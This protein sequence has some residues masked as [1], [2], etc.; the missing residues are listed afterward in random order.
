MRAQVFSLLFAAQ[1]LGQ[2]QPNASSSEIFGFDKVVEALVSA[3]DHADVVAL[4][5]DHWRKLDSD[6][7][8]QLIR[9]PRFA[10]KVR[11]IVVEFASTAQQPTLDRYIRGED[12]PLADLQKV[13]RTTTQT[14]GVWESSVY[15]DFF[16]AVRELNKSLPADSR[17]RV[18]AGDP[19]AGSG[20][21]RDDSAASIVKK[22]VLDK[23]G[24]ALVIYGA[25]HLWRTSPTGEIGLAGMLEANSPGRTFVVI[26]KG[27]TSKEYEIFERALK[28]SLRPVLVQLGKPP[29]R[30]FAADDLFGG[31][32]KK[33]VNGEWVSAFQ[34]SGITL[35]QMAD[36][37]IYLGMAPGVDTRIVPVRERPV[38]I[39]PHQSRRDE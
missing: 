26:T 5:D 36:A 15:A 16:G 12:V 2:Q 23:G 38:S 3:F 4:G 6:I 27:G 20:L 30:D 28:T 32:L 39:L 21:S 29:F 1:L 34:G 25:A 13:W 24:K 35:G 19:T 14:N 10:Q 18:L 9:H 8:I 33:R 11:F 37:C 22:H 31:D 7:R 17:V